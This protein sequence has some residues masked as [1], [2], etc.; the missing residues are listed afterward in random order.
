MSYDF[1]IIMLKLKGCNLAHS[2]FQIV[3][4]MVSN[5]LLSLVNTRPLKFWKETLA[6]LCSVSFPTPEIKIRHSLIHYIFFVKLILINC[7][8]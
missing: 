3:S 4:A 7:A 5:D 2:Y 6:L 1:A 8:L